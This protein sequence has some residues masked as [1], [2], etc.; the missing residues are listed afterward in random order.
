MP[1]GQGKLYA[2]FGHNRE[3]EDVPTEEARGRAR[4]D[5]GRAGP[6]ACQ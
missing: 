3:S 2:F 6:W 1:T 5:G 4:P